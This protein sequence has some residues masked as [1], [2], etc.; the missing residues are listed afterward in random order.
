MALKIFVVTRVPMMVKGEVIIN[1][2]N[3]ILNKGKGGIGTE[4]AL[5]T[6]KGCRSTVGNLISNM[7]SLLVT[8]SLALISLYG[9]IKLSSPIAM[10]SLAVP[11][12]SKYKPGSSGKYLTMTFL[13]IVT[14][15]R[16]N[17]TSMHLELEGNAKVTKHVAHI[18][19]SPLTAMPKFYC[20]FIEQLKHIRKLGV[21]ALY[22]KMIVHRI[23][24]LTYVQIMVFTL[25]YMGMTFR[26]TTYMNNFRSDISEEYRIVRTLWLE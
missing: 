3:L 2:I 16:S 25:L 7:T 20:V 4:T 15:V 23:N 1:C 19:F 18:D 17:V 26:T 24:T 22:S 21:A 5:N 9:S 10:T 13:H 14:A 12:P 8:G 6:M 11:I